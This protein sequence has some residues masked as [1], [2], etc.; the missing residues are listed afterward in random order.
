[1]SNQDNTKLVL[2]ILM[3][4]HHIEESLLDISEKEKKGSAAKIEAELDYPQFDGD[5]KEPLSL[6][7]VMVTLENIED[8]VR[9]MLLDKGFSSA[10]AIAQYQQYIYPKKD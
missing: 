7:D 2:D 3:S 9:C 4:L 6:Q 5:P 10:A 1:M 8:T